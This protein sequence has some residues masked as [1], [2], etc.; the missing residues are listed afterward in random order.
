M[1]VVWVVFTSYKGGVARGKDR[2]GPVGWCPWCGTGFTAS[3][4]SKGGGAQVVVVVTIDSVA[5]RVAVSGVFSAGAS[6]E[7]GRESKWESSPSKGGGS[8]GG[9]GQGML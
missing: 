7:A 8:E 1:G 9:D 2:V 6:S 5:V 3:G 4:A